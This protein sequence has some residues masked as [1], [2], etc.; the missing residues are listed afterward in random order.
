VKKKSI[1]VFF[2][3]FPVFASLPPFTSATTPLRLSSTDLSWFPSD[4][5]SS[6]TYFSFFPLME[7]DL[8]FV[9]V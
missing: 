7:I 9:T 8:S 1:G 2:F 3:S 5:N 6:P 4:Q